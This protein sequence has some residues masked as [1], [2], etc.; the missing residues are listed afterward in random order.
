[1]TKP[2]TSP[3]DGDRCLGQAGAEQAD[4]AHISA[5]MRR[6]PFNGRSMAGQWPAALTLQ[7]QTDDCQRCAFVEVHVSDECVLMT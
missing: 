3:H 2:P 4:N 1:M 5:G 7:C 6:N